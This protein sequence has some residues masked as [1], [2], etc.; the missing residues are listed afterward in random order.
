MSVSPTEMRLS[1][2]ASLFTKVL[3]TSIDGSAVIK[4]SVVSSVVLRS[5][6]SPS[7]LMSLVNLVAFKL[8]ATTK[9][10]FFT[11]PLSSADC[12]ITYVVEYVLDAPGDKFIG[13]DEVSDVVSDKALPA[14]SV[15]VS[16]RLN[17]FNV[18]TPVL[19]MVMV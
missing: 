9:T 14:A 8:L 7:S 5:V 2:S 16:V 19:V 12:S 13:S 15:S 18:C 3:V 6:S 17:P 1:P 11:P 4:T 10:L